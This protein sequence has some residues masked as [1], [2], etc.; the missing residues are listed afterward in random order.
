MSN[1]AHILDVLP[2]LALG[3]LDADEAVRAQEHL[4]SCVICRS[5]LSDFESLAAQM[6]FAI[7][8]VEPPP[9]LRN[10]LMERVQMPRPQPQS[11]PLPVQK[12]PS[13]SWWERLLPAWG[14][15]SLVLI[16]V[17]AAFNLLLWQRF[18]EMDFFTTPGG[19]RAVP[20]LPADAASPA[21][22]FVLVSVDGSDGALIVDGLPPLAED[23]EYQLWLSRDGEKI[24]GALFSTDEH[25]YGGT[26]IRAPR[27]LLEYSAAEITV[28]PTG[29]SSQP[30][31]VQVL[32]GPLHNP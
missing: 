24:S 4:S 30:T 15:A 28:E 22:G 13:R 12:V 23:Q 27:S 8:P 19:L 18:N 10:R 3:S 26:R 5:E 6:A 17:L 16:L 31:G 29:G 25:N 14:V 1:D 2:A 20:L 7:P 21:T 32:S 9:D 11:R